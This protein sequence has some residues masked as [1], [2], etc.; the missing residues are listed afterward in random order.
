ML[1]NNNALGCTYL[2]YE[3]NQT[4]EHFFTIGGFYVSRKN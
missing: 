4:L 2:T 1:H 3:K